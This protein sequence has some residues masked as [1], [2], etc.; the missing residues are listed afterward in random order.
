MTF[1][2]TSDDVVFDKDLGAYT[3]G[4]ATGI[5]TFRE[6]ATWHVAEE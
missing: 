1:I 4:L 3:T 5:T 6:D 2:V